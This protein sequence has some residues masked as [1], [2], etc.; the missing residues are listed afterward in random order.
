MVFKRDIRPL[1]KGGQVTKHDGKGSKSAP[2]S[3]RK[4]VTQSGA[5]SP[6]A[7]PNNYAKATPMPQ[8][9][10]APAPGIGSGDW[11]G[12]VG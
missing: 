1:T 8:Q 11:P 3:V 12:I 4:S 7:G 10:A 6:N 5:M 9:P 2:M